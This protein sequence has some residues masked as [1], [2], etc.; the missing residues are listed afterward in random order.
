[1]PLV[2][3]LSILAQAA[4]LIQPARRADDDLSEFFSLY[5][6]QHLENGREAQFLQLV[7]RQFK[8]ADGGVFIGMSDISK[9][10]REVT[11]ISSASAARLRVILGW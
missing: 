11:T 5:V 1:M 3:R 8:F 2:C 10:P 4:Q 9:L 6:I 7:L